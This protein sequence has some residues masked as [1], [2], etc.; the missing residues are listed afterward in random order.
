MQVPFCHE[1]M[2][3][4]GAFVLG[5]FGNLIAKNDTAMP[6]LQFRLLHSKYHLCSPPTRALLLSAYIKFVKIFPDLKLEIQVTCWF[7]NLFATELLK[8]S[9]FFFELSL[10]LKRI[11]IL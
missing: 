6:I 5:E 4:V 2:I 7:I 10:L 9:C 8:K 1:N 11:V 3:K